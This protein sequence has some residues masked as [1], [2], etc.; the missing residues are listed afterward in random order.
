MR[1]SVILAGRLR[2]EM[3]DF[4]PRRVMDYGLARVAKGLGQVLGSEQEETA[5]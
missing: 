4:H 2:V 3:S 5:R 1:L